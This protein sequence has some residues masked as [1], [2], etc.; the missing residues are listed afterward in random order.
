MTVFSPS[1]FGIHDRFP[2]TRVEERIPT[3]TLSWPNLPSLS[4]GADFTNSENEKRVGTL[5][6]GIN[7]FDFSSGDVTI[8]QVNRTESMTGSLNNLDEEFVRSL[9]IVAD[10]PFMWETSEGDNGY[11]RETLELE[12]SDISITSIDIKTQVPT[13][14]VV[15]GST[16]P[17]PVVRRT[18]PERLKTRISYTEN[19]NSTTTTLGT[20]YETLA[21]TT[22]AE[23]FKDNPQSGNEIY[24]GSVNKIGIVID[25][26]TVDRPVHVAARMEPLPETGSMP[27]VDVPGWKE[28]APMVVEQSDAKYFEMDTSSYD[29]LEF[30]ARNGSTN[31]QAFVEMAVF[32]ITE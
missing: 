32:G 26:D 8:P 19:D 18:G 28:S 14:A 15:A 27:T 22:V 11:E 3:N 25:N 13:G 31:G 6:G 4:T 30:R 10:Q 29:N 1:D 16:R 7:K 12:L 2:N 5:V 9:F 21:F 20:S 23:T 24:V 17:T